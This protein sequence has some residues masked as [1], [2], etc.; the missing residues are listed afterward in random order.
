MGNPQMTEF[1][2][3]RRDKILA[4]VQAFREE[5][6]YSPTQ[7]EIADHIGASIASVQR[8]VGKLEDEGKVRTTPRISRSIVPV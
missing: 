2:E 1:G 8:H 3:H 7:Q 6:G 4:F 5:H